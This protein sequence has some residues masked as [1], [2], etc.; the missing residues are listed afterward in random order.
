MADGTKPDYLVTAKVNGDKERWT[1]IGAA[2]NSVGS[3]TG[4]PYISVRLSS[5][6][7]TWDGTLALHQCDETESRPE[8]TPVD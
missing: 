3:R 5:L 1:T 2:W 4:K 8:R 6:P 7:M